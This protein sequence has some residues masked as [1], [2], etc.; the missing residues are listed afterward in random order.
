M[1]EFEKYIRKLWDDMPGDKPDILT[2]GKEV[3]RAMAI[4]EAEAEFNALRNPYLWAMRM[5]NARHCI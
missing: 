1:T 3:V 4:G 5:F 2:A